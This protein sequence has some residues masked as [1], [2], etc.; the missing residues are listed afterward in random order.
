MS[1]YCLVGR[2]RCSCFTHGWNLNF[3]LCR[4]ISLQCRLDIYLTK[5]SR[6]ISSNIDPLSF[7]LSK[8]FLLLFPYFFFSLL[9]SHA[10]NSFLYRLTLCWSDSHVGFHTTVTWPT[11]RSNGR[12]R[13]VSWY[14]SSEWQSPPPVFSVSDATTMPSYR[15]AGQGAEGVAPRYRVAASSLGPKTL[16]S[17]TIL[18][19][20]ALLWSLR[21]ERFGYF[22]TEQ[23]CLPF[24][25]GPLLE[26][27]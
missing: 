27:C 7:S 22:R 25:W 11:Q 10:I 13:T 2:I 1:R 24:S 5:N 26:L 8:K 16:K 12:R 17:F 3:S 23:M 19:L 21:R 14:R 6:H 18:P 4:H 20:V 9:A 15:H